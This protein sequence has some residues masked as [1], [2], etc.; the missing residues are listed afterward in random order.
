LK[1]KNRAI[2]I[3]NVQAL[4]GS[5]LE[6]TD[7]LIQ[8]GRFSEFGKD[9]SPPSPDTVMIDGTERIALPGIIDAHTHFSLRQG[10]HK[11]ADD[12]SSGS[13]SA[14]F[15]GVTFFIDYSMQEK[16]GSLKESV[17]SRIKEAEG[18]SYID[19]SFHA[20]ITDWNRETENEALDLL[21]SGFPSFKMFLIYRDKGWLSDDSKIFD[22]LSKL[23][24]KGG[25]IEV[26]CE[27][28]DLIN[29]LTEKLVKDNKTQ[30][31][32][33]PLSRPDFTEAEAVNR[34]I[35][36][37]RYAKGKLYIVHVSSLLSAEIIKE[38]KQRKIPVFAETCPQYLSINSNVFSGKEPE[39]YAT[40]PPVRN[41]ENINGIWKIIDEGFF[42]TIATDH[43]AFFKSQKELGKN[44]FRKLAFGMPGTEYS[45]PVIFTEGH[46]KRRI[47]IEKISKLMS[48]N[49]A[50]IF[51]LTGRGKIEKGYI[52]DIFI[53]HPEEKSILSSK[54]HHHPLDYSP[55]EGKEVYGVPETVIA[56]GEIKVLNRELTGEMNGVLTKRFV[57]VN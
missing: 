2:I 12:F 32:Y 35:F 40:C 36:L 55:Y 54:T 16:S 14:L 46:I 48:E 42:D 18:N 21:E 5:N 47:E 10:T 38:A 28:N 13:R 52:A 53:F 51:G 19:Y 25:I 7:I 44:D 23:G 49:P 4:L 15:G 39:L 43:C 33:H 11:T 9:L 29:L 22:A 45:F 26:H 24:P 6:K 17:R 57:N 56:N 41:E 1:K 31:K 37:N 20:G 27:N 50:R 3:S 34:M 8:D 30:V